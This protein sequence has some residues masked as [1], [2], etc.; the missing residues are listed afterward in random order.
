MHSSDG[1]DALEATHL[2]APGALITVFNVESRL[3]QGPCAGKGGESSS[4]L[5]KK[6]PEES[7]RALPACHPR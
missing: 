4:T 7:A 3:G 5:R 2:K 6:E 1:N